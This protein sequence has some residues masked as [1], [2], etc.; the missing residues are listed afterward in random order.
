VSSTPA[1]WQGRGVR[2]LLLMPAAWLFRALAALRRYGYQTGLFRVNAESIPVFVVGN[3]SVGG[4]GKTPL[5]QAFVKMAT[6]Q[7]VACGVVSRGH[8]GEKHVSPYVVSDDTR[9]EV[10]GDEPLLHRL[11]TSTPVVVCRDRS[12]AV[13]QLSQLGAKL[14]ISDDG[15]QHY[16]MPRKL[17]VVVVDGNVGFSNAQLLPAGPL[18]EPI[19]RLSSVDIIAVQVSMQAQLPDVN[20]LLQQLPVLQDA[21]T[22]GVAMGSFALQAQGLRHLWSHAQVPLDS[23]AGRSVTAMAGIGSPTRFFNVLQ[24]AN[25]VVTCHEFAD[26]H[27]YHQDDFKNISGTPIIVTGK[28]A[29]KLRDLPLKSLDIYELEVDVVLSSELDKAMRLAIQ[30]HA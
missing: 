28:D 2:T 20:L 29:V 17:E 25:M 22:S 19:T 1:H 10:V 23:M 9:A 3:I 8:G 16:A 18:R 30:T 24:D 21:K 7:G 4:T 5:T 6:S 27:R 15:L 11:K 13:N 14:A 26:H 12:A